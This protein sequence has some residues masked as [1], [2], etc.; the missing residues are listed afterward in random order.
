MTTGL[1]TRTILG[2]IAVAALVALAGCGG[3]SGG[4]DPKIIQGAE[5]ML[6]AVAGATMQ[7]GAPDWMSARVS[8]AT[9][10]DTHVKHYGDAA[11]SI[12]GTARVTITAQPNPSLAG[13]ARGW[14]SG[15]TVE[16]S[17][18]FVGR[19][20]KQQGR[21]VSQSLTL[22]LPPSEDQNASAP[23]SDTQPPPPP[24]AAAAATA[25]VRDL[26]TFDGN[27]SAYNQRQVAHYV[28]QG[29]PAA[30]TDPN[31][32]PPPTLRVPTKPTRVVPAPRLACRMPPSGSR[33][34]RSPH[35][36]IRRARP[37]PILCS[38]AAARAPATCRH[39]TCA[40]CT[41]RRSHRLR[42]WTLRAERRSRWSGC[43]SPPR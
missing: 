35:R 38:A 41:R 6:P 5:R 9:I 31:V 37:S 27:V 25:A 30:F 15:F 26:F 10:Q 39:S 33:P 13:H 8:H 17:Y 42:R 1:N 2:V 12:D 20:N 24:A 14:A 18:P 22:R 16:R 28:T 3:A 43:L 23:S 34:V 11:A 40:R 36:E 19:A 4:D 7:L 32:D 29:D 21:W